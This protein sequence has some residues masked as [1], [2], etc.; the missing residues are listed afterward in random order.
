[1]R[2]RRK[3]DKGGCKREGRE[4]KRRRKGR[5]VGGIKDLSKV[6]RRKDKREGRMKKGRKEALLP[7]VNIWI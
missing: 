4:R 1:M 6:R 3:G 2:V 5:R 7:T